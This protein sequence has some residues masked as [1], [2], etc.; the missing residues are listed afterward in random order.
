MTSLAV[1]SDTNL[2]SAVLRATRPVVAAFVSPSCAASA[3]L[4]P[5]L[6]QLAVEY[7]GRVLAVAINAEEETLLV[8]QFSIACTPTLLVVDRGEPVTRAV[9]FAPLGLIRQLF[10][11]TAS[12]NLARHW[13]W[14]PTEEVFE[15]TVIAP[16][17]QRWGWRFIRQ[18]P[19]PLPTSK[20]IRGR[21][22]FLAYLDDDDDP[23]TLFENKR[24]IASQYDLQQAVVQART[25][26][27][28]LD[29]RSFVVAAPSGMWV[30]AREGKRTRSAGTFSSLDL[31]I[32]PQALATLLLE[33]GRRS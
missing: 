3:A 26:A 8:E 30:Y 9:G 16:L 6:E 25:Y 5:I 20:G 12:S 23:L 27:A 15:E 31:H 29:A 19:C 21:I 1:V 7:A 17:L 14:S 4:L 2:G 33:L 22:D 13:L 28:A 11:D 18:A 32:N 24:Q 10:V